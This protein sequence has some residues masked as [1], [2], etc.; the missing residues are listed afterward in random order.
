MRT[1]IVAVLKLKRMVYKF[2]SLRAPTIQPNV[3]FID[4]ALLPC[5]TI[6]YDSTWAHSRTAL[7]VA[8]MAPICY[9]TPVDTACEQRQSLCGRHDFGRV[10]VS[11][12]WHADT[13]KLFKQRKPHQQCQM[14]IMCNCYGQYVEL[15]LGPIFGTISWRIVLGRRMRMLMIR[16]DIWTIFRIVLLLTIKLWWLSLVCAFMLWASCG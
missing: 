7:C 9:L 10:W 13:Y 14:F 6:Q 11:S 15:F 5:R 12:T 3:H 2:T 4:I 1:Y 8:R 16:K